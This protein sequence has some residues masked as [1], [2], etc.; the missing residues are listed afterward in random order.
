MSFRAL[1]GMVVFPVDVSCKGFRGTLKSPPS[2]SVP[3]WKGVRAVMTDLKNV[4]WCLLG[5]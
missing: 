5:A 4:T 3:S 2:I 1:Y